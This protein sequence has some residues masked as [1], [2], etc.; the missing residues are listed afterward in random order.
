MRRL[1]LIFLLIL[2]L[3][4]QS[5]AQK[6]LTLNDAVDL[7][8]EY[9]YGIQ[10]A[11]SNLEIAE[12]NNA[13]G[14]AGFLPVV[15]I[16]ANQNNSRVN[17]E[18]V[19]G[20]DVRDIDNQTNSSTSV[21]ANLNWTLFDG[22]RMFVNQDILQTQNLQSTS[23]LEF[24]VE[25]VIF[26]VSTNFYLASLEDERL[27]LLNENL[28]LSEERLRITK[29][30]Y[31]LGK[32]SKLAFL[33]AQVDYNTDQSNILNQKQI[34]ETQKLE[35]LRQIGIR[36]TSFYALDYDLTLENG[37][38]LDDLLNNI[39]IGNKEVDIFRRATEVAALQER[40]SKADRLPSLSIFTGY[41]YSEAQR[42]VGFSFES[43]TTDLSYGFNASVTIFN[44]FNINR[45]IQNNKINKDIAE[46][47][48]EQRLLDIETD[49]RQQYLAYLNSLELIKLE[50]LNV[51]VAKENNDIAQER[52]EIGLSNAVEYRESQINLIAAELR[53]QNA[54]FAAKISEIELKYLAGM[55]IQ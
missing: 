49:L 18:Q 38:S 47:N 34:L 43:T 20:S 27:L 9:N 28:K 8:L 42:A 37:I 29:D 22:T 35:L 19:V 17:G 51:L 25:T 46:L 32:A 2:S 54:K 21:G 53:E 41:N 6:D 12:N 4:A 40:A 3:A 50:Q 24:A 33:Q 44:G 16:D 55:S 36:D 11:R 13:I 14:N 5:I 15:T 1:L 48:Y 31:E 23:Q 39:E 30:R 26:N 10:I 7:A 52:Y 45:D